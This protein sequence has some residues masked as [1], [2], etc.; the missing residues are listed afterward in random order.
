LF[1]RGAYDDAAHAL[2]P[3]IECTIREICRRAGLV[4]SREPIGPE[5]GGVRSLGHLLAALEGILDESWRRYLVNSLTEP[6]GVNLRNRIAHGLI[7]EAQAHDA[8]LLIHV[9]AFLRTLESKEARDVG[10]TT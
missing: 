6:L 7:G 9:A 4:V 3:R 8:A 5:P 1:A 10:P 2:A